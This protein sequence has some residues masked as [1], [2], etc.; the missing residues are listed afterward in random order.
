MQAAE[1][2][3]TYQYKND[4]ITFK[5]TTILGDTAYVKYDDGETGELSI[6]TI[7]DSLGNGD[8]INT[9]E[10]ESE[11][12]PVEDIDDTAEIPVF[13]FRKV[14][15]VTTAKKIALYYRP[16]RLHPAGEAHFPGELFDDIADGFDRFDIVFDIGH[17]P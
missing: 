2:G 14:S 15:G 5:I 17:R 11:E 4:E 10:V 1:L 6:E 12:E 3:R 16:H 7:N 9:G 8:L 13:S